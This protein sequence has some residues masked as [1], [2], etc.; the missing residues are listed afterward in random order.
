MGVE[1][2]RS[3]KSQRTV[4]PLSSKRSCANS[5][6]RTSSRS[7][8]PLRGS[9][10]HTTSRRLS[11]SSLLMVPIF[12]KRDSASVTRLGERAKAATRARPLPTSSWM[13]LARRVRMRRSFISCSAAASRARIRFR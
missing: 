5:R 6:R 13:S 12:S 10:I 4:A 3:G 2:S 7:K 1:G 8:V 11:S 9:F